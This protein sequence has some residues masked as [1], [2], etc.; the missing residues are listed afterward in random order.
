[1]TCILNIC[2]YFSSALC[3]LVFLWFCLLLHVLT[4]VIAWWCWLNDVVIGLLLSVWGQFI[5]SSGHPCKTLFQYVG[6]HSVTW[7]FTCHALCALL[8][9]FLSSSKCSDHFLMKCCVWSFVNI[10][11]KFMYGLFL[12]DTFILG[13][14]NFYIWTIDLWKTFYFL[15]WNDFYIRLHIEC[16]FCLNIFERN[17]LQVCFVL[18]MSLSSWGH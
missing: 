1:M 13:W 2:I 17:F 15:S 5:T 8:S 16:L 6:H 7:S 18:K 14:F 3:F 10:V 11:F 12:Y 9:L 4:I